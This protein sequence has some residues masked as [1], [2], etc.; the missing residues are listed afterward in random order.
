[1][2]IAAHYFKFVVALVAV[3]TVVGGI[4]GTWLGA[5]L[6][7]MYGSLIHFPFLVYIK[8][9]DVYV[10][11][12][13]LSLVA[14]IAGAARALR[15]VAV[16]PPAVAMQ[17][18]APPRFR[19]VLPAGLALNKRISQATM[20]MLRNLSHHPLRAIFTTLGVALATAIIIVSLFLRDTT[21]DLINITYFIANRQDATVSF[22]ERRPQ[23]V[24]EQIA[25]L[26]GV[27]AV[28][29]YREVPV[30]IRN[31]SIERRII[32][33]R[34]RGGDLRRIIDVNLR[35]VALP[36][37]GLAVSA[38]LAQILGVRVGDLVE[39]D[40]L[41]GQRRTVSLPVS[42]LVED[43]FGIQGMMELEGSIG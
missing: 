17:P 31:G 36:E 20:I 34:P 26:P 15:A 19:H 1:M 6:T 33:G 4:A 11:G 28:E 8:N 14:G 23:N 37:N 43:F 22:I 13:L 18:P 39:V 27:L 41:E 30:R 35:S 40:L 12:G 32:S 7:R 24:V 5:F 2:T 3:G 10:F 16:L 9:S 25:H 38:W 21:E 29:P 42:A